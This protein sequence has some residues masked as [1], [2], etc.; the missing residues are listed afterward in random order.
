MK[1]R[2]HLLFILIG[3]VVAVL[4]ALTPRQPLWQMS[5]ART[6]RYSGF[7]PVRHEWHALSSTSEKT[8]W[9]LETRAGLGSEVIRRVK[10]A[11]PSVKGEHFYIRTSL[12]RRDAPLVFIALYTQYIG[13]RL[14]V[15]EPVWLLH[16]QTGELLRETPIL[17]GNM[18]PIAMHGNRVA[19][20]DSEGIHLFEGLSGASRFLKL[21]SPYDLHFSTDG[22]LLVC[23]EKNTQKLYTIDWD[24]AEAHIQPVNKRI[25]SIAFISPDVLLIFDTST[26]NRWKWDGKQFNAISPGIAAFSGIWPLQHKIHRSGRLQ[27]LASGAI[28]WAPLFDTFFTW[29]TQHQ[30]PVER[31][32]PKEGWQHWRLVDEQDQVVQEFDEPRNTNGYKIYDDLVVEPQPQKDGSTILQL[33]SHAP[34]W[35]N[36]LAMG[37]ITYLLLYVGM[38]CVQTMKPSI[39]PD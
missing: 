5:D 17:A 16:P 7:D 3:S 8:D 14:T 36:A 21:K 18:V 4:F 35:P 29:L 31:W 1:L 32:I 33:W 25:Y 37:M 39:I 10:L 24:R 6:V 13:N 34:M 15:E 23:S 2:W 11:V 22:S 30:V 12:G 9:Q 19:I 28:Q 20:A 27:V 38:R 26:V